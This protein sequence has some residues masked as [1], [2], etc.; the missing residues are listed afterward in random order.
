LWRPFYTHLY[1][2]VS[3]VDQIIA[4]Q[5]AQARKAG[6]TIDQVV[7][8]HGVS[9]VRVPLSERPEGRRLFDMLRSGDIRKR[10][11]DPLLLKFC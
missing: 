4:H 6:F 7:S 5:E 10:L 2:R 11:A 3:T 8:D 9:G 1:A